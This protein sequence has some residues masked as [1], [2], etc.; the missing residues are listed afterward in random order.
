MDFSDLFDQLVSALQYYDQLLIIFLY[1]LLVTILFFVIRQGL[2][3]FIFSGLDYLAGIASIDIGV[4]LGR[5]SE[6]VLYSSPDPNGT[7][8]KFLLGKFIVTVIAY[9]CFLWFFEDRVVAYNC[10][11]L[12]K[13]PT[14]VIP[15]YYIIFT[16]LFSIS[17]ITTT[18]FI[19]IYGG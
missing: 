2:G 13:S 1:P 9:V 5:L 18:I 8:V 7:L 4:I 15:I 10:G 16:W 12:S 11:A 6:S 17:L 3:G 14:G 19:L